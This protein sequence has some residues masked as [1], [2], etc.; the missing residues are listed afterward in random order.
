MRLTIKGSN[1]TAKHENISK[2]LSGY[3]TSE[4]INRADYALL[5]TTVKERIANARVRATLSANRELVSLYWSIGEIIVNRQITQGRGSAVIKR[6]SSDIR[7]EF[8]GIQGFSIRNIWS[9]RSFYLTYS[10]HVT[11]VPRPVAFNCDNKL[12]QPVAD[13]DYTKLPRPVAEMETHPILKL[14]T[15]LPWGHNI[16]LIQMVKDLKAR[17]WYMQQTVEHGWS[18]TMLVLHIKQGDYERCGKA[19]TNFKET[20]PPVQS[21][22]AQGILKDPYL[23]DFLGLTNDI[24]ERELEN[25]LLEHLREFLIELGS[26]FAFVGN[27]Y[28]LDIDEEDYYI[29]LL[30]YHLK[31]RCYFVIDLKTRPFAAE[32]A[33][34][35]NFYLNAVDDKLKHSD[36]NPSVGLVLCREKNGSNRMVLEYALRGLNKP[37]GVSE[38]QLTRALPDNLKPSLPTIEEIEQQIAAAEIDDVDSET[39]MLVREMQERYGVRER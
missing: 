16:D 12:Q 37:I 38:Y 29:D 4:P 30:F 21:D 28:R 27:Q 18:R 2:Q 22:L 14:V 17:I 10:E 13:N 35:M 6:L 5:L 33:G 23:F 34:K 8:S 36:D 9:M 3:S 7:K 31:L 24:R 32:D 11:K 20:L 19:V 1:M 15:Q 39:G 25:A 26:G